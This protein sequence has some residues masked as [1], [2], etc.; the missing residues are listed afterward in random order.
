MARFVLDQVVAT[1]ATTIRKGHP[2]RCLW[3]L[4]PV[5]FP[6]REYLPPGKIKNIFASLF[7]KL[8]EACC[9]I[10]GSP[11]VFC[12][13]EAKLQDPLRVQPCIS[14][15]TPCDAGIKV[16]EFNS[17]MIECLTWE[18]TEKNDDWLHLELAKVSC[19]KLAK[20]EAW[21]DHK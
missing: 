17:S 8:L 7:K 12:P 1:L 5:S 9:Q 18:T 4:V 21:P 19:I 10:K 11:G 16:D 20:V 6:K 13:S 2:L 15:K 3:S 14:P